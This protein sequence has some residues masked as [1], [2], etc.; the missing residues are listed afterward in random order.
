MADAILFAIAVKFALLPL[1]GW[2][3][4]LLALRGRPSGARSVVGVGSCLLGAV[5]TAYFI[6]VFDL[7]PFAQVPNCGGALALVIAHIV[8][9]TARGKTTS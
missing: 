9:Y 5:A 4:S 8:R 3:A 1:V 6:Y 7:G 2:G